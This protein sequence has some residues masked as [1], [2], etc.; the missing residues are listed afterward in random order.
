MALKRIQ[1]WVSVSISTNARGQASITLTYGNF[2][3]E[4]NSGFDKN[5]LADI[6]A[7]LI[8]LC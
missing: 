1:M 4:I 3:I 5:V 8:G 7:V 2:K 6:L